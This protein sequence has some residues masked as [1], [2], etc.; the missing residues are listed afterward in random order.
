MTLL[1]ITSRDQAPTAE[2]IDAIRKVFEKGGI[3]ILP[4]DT[5]YGLHAPAN[6][7]YA[8]ARI[9]EAKRRAGSQPLVVL[10]SSIDQIRGLGVQM[11]EST[12]RALD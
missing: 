12:A 9:F 8:V 3:A 2:E 7:S 5:L 4:T 1:R 10:C 6:N 11:D